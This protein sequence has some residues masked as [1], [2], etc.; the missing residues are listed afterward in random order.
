ME[1]RRLGKTGQMSSI[2]T[3]GGA[4]LWLVSQA[5]A[6]AGIEMAIQHGINHIDVAPQYGQAEM[7]LG[8]WLEKHRAGIFLACKTMERTKIKAWESIKQSLKTLRVDHFDLFQFHGVDDLE[9]LTKVLGHGGA[10][11]AVLEAKQQGLI[12]FIGI[13]GHRPKIIIEAMNRFDFDTVLFPVNRGMAAHPNDSN[14]FNTLLQ[15]A[16][17]H[18]VGTIAIKAIAKSHWEQPMHM[19]KTWYVPFE[20]QNDI[21]KS[22]WY[23]LSQDITTAALPGDLRL[24]PM[25]INAAERFS[26]MNAQKQVEAVSE[27]IQYAS[28]FPLE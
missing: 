22:L 11:E 2:V 9:T 17:K 16:H 15:V 27:V 28:L 21:D 10:L 12:R 4:A 14:D 26:P 24:W 25:V 18:D 6:N 13:T 8:P 5:E 1:K 3:F 20:E 23:T 19:Y 7:R